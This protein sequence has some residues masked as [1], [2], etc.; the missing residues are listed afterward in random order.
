MYNLT[1]TGKING[2]IVIAETAANRATEVREEP[3]NK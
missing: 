2:S 3:E 1:N